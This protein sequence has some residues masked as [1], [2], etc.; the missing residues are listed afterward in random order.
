MKKEKK[1]DFIKHH[2]NHIV[3]VNDNQYIGL[4]HNFLEWA[5]QN[6]R[7]VDT[8]NKIVYKRVAKAINK[9]R[10]LHTPGKSVVYL[11]IKLG[12]EKEL[13]SVWIQ[14]FEDICP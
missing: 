8:M 10:I 14:L 2:G 6:F 5:V 13:H 9:N 7:Y 3:F 1:G 11:N 12:D 4:S